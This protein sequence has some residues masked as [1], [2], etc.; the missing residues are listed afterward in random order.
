ML[1]TQQLTEWGWPSSC[2][3]SE[4]A[5]LVVVELAANAVTHGRVKGR[6]FRLTLAVDAPDT[7]RIEVADPRDD[8]PLQPRTPALTAEYGRGLLLVDALATP[9]GRA[10]DRLGQRPV[11]AVRQDRLGMSPTALTADARHS[12]SVPVRA[13]PAAGRQW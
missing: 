11:P 7:L 10:G 3:A 6:C 12:P 2:T 1:A 8:R 5:A 13:D 4:S 9:R